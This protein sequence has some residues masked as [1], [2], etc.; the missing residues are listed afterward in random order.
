[1]ITEGNKQRAKSFLTLPLSS[2]LPGGG[3]T[4]KIRRT[5]SYNLPI[6]KDYFDFGMGISAEHIWGTDKKKHKNDNSALFYPALR[7]LKNSLK[8][9]ISGDVSSRLD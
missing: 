9:W 4:K 7:M 5:P 2:L 3:R 1:M 8:T 6:L